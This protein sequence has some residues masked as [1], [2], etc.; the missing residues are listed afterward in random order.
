MHIKASY[1]SDRR[2]RVRFTIVNNLLSMRQL[3]G[4]GGGFDND[5][6]VVEHILYIKWGSSAYYAVFS[7]EFYSI[8]L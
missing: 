5:L 1:T 2:E 7:I 8:L 3:D 4:R 6:E